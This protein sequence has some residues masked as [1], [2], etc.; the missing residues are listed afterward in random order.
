[1]GVITFLCFIKP[2]QSHRHWSAEINKT[3]FFIKK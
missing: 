3:D 1:L 2:K